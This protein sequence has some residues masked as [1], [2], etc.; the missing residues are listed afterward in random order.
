[1]RSTER[2]ELNQDRDHKSYYN[3]L[4]TPTKKGRDLC[5]GN[6]PVTYR[7]G[8]YGTTSRRSFGGNRPSRGTTTGKVSGTKDW[9]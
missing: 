7:S 8:E 5:F 2:T 6:R 4:T 9:R 3:T 1:M